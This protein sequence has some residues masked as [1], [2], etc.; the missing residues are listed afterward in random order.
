MSDILYENIDITRPTWWALWIGPQQQHQPGWDW[1]TR[2]NCD[3]DFP[4]SG[5]SHCPTQPR[6]PIDRVTLRDV[7]INEPL[8]SPGVIRCN[9][10]RVD[11]DPAT[12]EEVP[13]DRDSCSE[14]AFE[15]VVVTR[16]G[17][18]KDEFPFGANFRCWNAT[19][20]A[21]AASDPVPDC[22]TP[23]SAS[24]AAASLASASY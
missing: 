22:L 17:V 16:G 5:Y 2:Q 6:V 9:G 12:G 23:L 7:R 8:L 10:S 24:T 13:S 1:K 21:D 19:G 11:L 15:N 14:L 4:L 18:V 20:T 3:L